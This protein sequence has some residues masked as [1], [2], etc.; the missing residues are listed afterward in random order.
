MKLFSGSAN[1]KLSEEVA[2]LLNV[3]LAK[4]EVVHFENSEV[5]VRIEEN[6]VDEVCYVIQPTSNPTDTHLMELFL[7]ADA[8]KRSD[9]K[10]IIAVIPYFGYARQNIQHRP[11]E[12]VSTNVVVNFLETIGFHEIITFDLHDEA[13][14]GIFTVPFSN[15]TSFSVLANSIVEYLGKESINIKDV[16]IVSPDQ[17]GVERARR[18]GSHLFGTD[19]FP[20]TVIEKNRDQNIIHKSSAVAIYGEVGDKIVILIDDIL[21]S[22]GTMFNAADLCMSKG[23]KRVIGAV[24]H[25]DFA[26]NTREKIEKSIIEK[27]F[28]TNT[29]VLREEDISSKIV[30]ASVASLIAEN[31]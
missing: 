15:L 26:P 12:C 27:L 7:F 22:G 2:R 16:M 13:T 5:R 28:T 30:E 10:K 21:T 8:L 6:V 11:G 4:S 31:I 29:I 9:A 20:I 3:P 18:F 1:L 24:V 25:H 23:A 17:G 14:M 19:D